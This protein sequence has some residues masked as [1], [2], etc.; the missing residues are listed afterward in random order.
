MHWLKCLEFAHFIFELESQFYFF[1]NFILI[2]WSCPP[3]SV[4]ITLF[5]KKLKFKDSL[6]NHQVLWKDI[7]LEYI[8]YQKKQ[9]S[10]YI[11]SH[12]QIK[13]VPMCSNTIKLP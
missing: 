11:H 6:N 13:D 7:C 12:I 4:E 2:C 1:A 10:L 9:K 5:F 8:K 3:V